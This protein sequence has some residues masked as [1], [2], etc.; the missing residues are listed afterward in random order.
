MIID[1]V[2]ISGPCTFE[3]DCAANDFVVECGRTLTCGDFTCSTRVWDVRMH[4]GV[5]DLMRPVSPDL[6]LQFFRTV[7]YSD[8]KLAA[9]SVVLLGSA[10]IN[11]G[12]VSM[13]I[14]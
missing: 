8:A 13:P 2:D 6:M 3:Q 4:H 9:G 5:Q 14:Q 10:E 7:Y 1:H 11:I 12:I